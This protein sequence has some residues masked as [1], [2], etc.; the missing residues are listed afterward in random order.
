MFM[1]DWL[2]VILMFLL[3]GSSVANIYRAGQLSAGREMVEKATKANVISRAL[4][5][6]IDIMIALIIMYYFL[7]WEHGVHG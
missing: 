2:A 5:G 4:A 3:I 6:V 7:W 1:P